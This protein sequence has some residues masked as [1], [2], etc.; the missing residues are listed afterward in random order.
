MAVVA[1]VGDDGGALVSLPDTW[2]I[3]GPYRVRLLDARLQE[4]P[5]DPAGVAYQ[6]NAGRLD[7]AIDCYTDI[8][9]VALVVALPVCPTG[10]YTLEITHGVGFATT[11]A[12]T[13]EIKVQRRTRRPSAWSQ[14]SG[15]P[16]L[17]KTGPRDLR[18]EQIH[19][20]AL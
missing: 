4:N 16:S 3:T 12:T 5:S 9:K 1:T 7:K 19:R 14:R 20:G 2:P 17:Y 8:D 10:T 11:F 15:F 13:D 6:C 18:A